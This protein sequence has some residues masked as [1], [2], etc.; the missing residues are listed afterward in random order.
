MMR[1]VGKDCEK[2]MYLATAGVNTHK[3]MLFSLSLIC[4]AIGRLWQQGQRLTIASICHTVAQATQGI[5]ELV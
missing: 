1:P 4:A 5:V 3:G 2:A